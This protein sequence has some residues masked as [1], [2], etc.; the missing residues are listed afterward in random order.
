MKRMRA[1][2]KTNAITRPI[3]RQVLR[4]NIGKFVRPSLEKV[5]LIAPLRVAKLFYPSISTA[6]AIPKSTKGI[7]RVSLYARPNADPEAAREDGPPLVHRHVWVKGRTYQGMEDND[8]RGFVDGRYVAAWNQ[9]KQSHVRL[10][11]KPT[12]WARH[13]DCELF[14]VLQRWDGLWLPAGS[15][16]SSARLEL[17]VERGVDREL[18]VLLY[19]VHRNWIPGDG[20]LL[21]NN[22]SAP[23]RG[24]VWWNE[25]GRETGTWGLPGANFASDAHPDAD[26]PLSP[27]ALADYRPGAASIS[28]E[29]REL[30]SYVQTRIAERRPLLFLLKLS[31]YLEDIPGTSIDVYSANHGD[32]RNTARRP[33]LVL[34]WNGA[35][36]TARFERHV[37]LEHGRSVELPR[38]ESEATAG[39]AVS[40]VPENGKEQPTIF[41]RGDDHEGDTTEWINSDFPREIG[42]SSVEVRLD[43]CVDPVTFGREFETEIRDTWVTTGTPE[44]QDVP[45]TFIS[46][47]GQEHVVLGEY[48]GDSRW[49]IRFLPEE[50][51]RWRYQWSQ[52]FTKRPYHSSIGL[53][54][55]IPGDRASVLH[56]LERLTERMETSEFPPG[57]QR[58]RV[59]SSEF[60][61]L[62]RAV[63][64]HET[65]ESFPLSRSE[66]DGGEVG[67]RLDEVREIMGGKRPDRPRLA[68]DD[69][70][71]VDRG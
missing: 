20:G 49:Q 35:Q 18:E 59:F 26:T 70:E 47:S 17:E 56:A 25:A 40:F 24:E 39:V 12:S 65:P 7:V 44:Q 23:A 13:G 51:G 2:L 32:S 68:I 38:I 30:A 45:C 57:R 71:G 19:E 9:P 62:L 69:P 63:I 34:K 61:R 31:D 48:V 6:G 42:W 64:G 10:G 4:S 3:I 52:H 14:R 58:A 33:R 60:N 22:N 16:V 28:F 41:M 67:L 27:L 46:P 15:T 5:G 55:V 43:A 8:L 54:D 50:L 53:F 11:R 21:R 29:S 36:E 1:L 37:L 66:P